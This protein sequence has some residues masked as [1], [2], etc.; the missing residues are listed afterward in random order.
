M[1]IFDIKMNDLRECY[2][3][4]YLM[5]TLNTSKS[6]KSQELFAVNFFRYELF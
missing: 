5:N 6:F 2:I 4:R 1:G 3:I